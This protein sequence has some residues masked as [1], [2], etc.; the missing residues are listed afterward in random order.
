MLA[1]DLF[2]PWADILCRVPNLQQNEYLYGFFLHFIQN[3][4]MIIH[5][6]REGLYYG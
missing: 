5:N 6:E 4:C 2:R 3:E 1:A